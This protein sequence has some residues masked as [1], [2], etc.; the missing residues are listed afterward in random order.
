MQWKLPP[1]VRI[2]SA[3]RPIA[4]R[5]GKQRL[6]R[7]DR[8][9]VV[10]CAVERDDDGRI[11]DVEVHV[12]GR[13]D[14]AVALDQAGRGDGDDLEIGVEQRL[15]RIGI[16]RGIGVVV[17][18]LRNGDAARPDEA[19]EIVDMA[20]GMV[21][22][23]AVAEPDDAVAPRSRFSRSSTSSLV[24]ARVAVGVEQA[25]LGGEEGARPVAVDRSALQD[26]VGLGVGQA[27]CG[28]EPLADAVVARQGHI[29]RPSR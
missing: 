23:Q 21:V 29:C 2:W 4:R 18:R 24:E 11:A 1:P 3:R 14:L 15:G 6:D 26:P 8:G 19:R 16:G 9:A 25:L 10:G 12:A 22:E 5:S 27:S 13:D 17:D 28:G 20:V 7:L